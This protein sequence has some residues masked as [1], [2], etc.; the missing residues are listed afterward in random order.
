MLTRGFG[1]KILVISLKRS[2]DRRAAAVSQMT[3]LGLPFEFFDA[4][5]G[6][7]SLSQSFTG[8]NRWLFRINALRDP[9]PGEIG[10]Y[11]SH[12]ELWKLAASQGQPIV[13]LEDDFQL[14]PG[15]ADVFHQLRPLVD[16]FGFIRLEPTVRR[17]SVVKRLR[18]ATREVYRQGELRIRF[19]CDP[20]VRLLA[21]AIG[22]RAA[23]SLTMASATLTAPV[24]KFLQ[25]T[26]MHKTPLFALDPPVVDLSEHS[27][28]ST[29]GRK[30]AKSLNPVLLSARGVY[31]GVAE[32][33]R[34][35]F[36]RQQLARLSDT[37]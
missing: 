23:L 36:N 14:E 8:Y 25:H 17:R 9:T 29:L 16:T 15:F 7:A 34:F 1:L 35:A 13:I 3:A 10:C 6:D 31:R 18:R 28:R 4:V 21:Y 27:E 11:A 12:L 37:R 22:P 30:T 19:M 2:A 32:F 33:R 20:P 24:D 26:W 5:D